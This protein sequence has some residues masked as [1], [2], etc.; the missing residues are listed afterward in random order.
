[1]EEEGGPALLSD[2]AVLGMDE[3]VNKLMLL[4]YV[5]EFCKAKS[6]VPFHRQYFAL[7]GANGALQFQ[8]FLSLVTYLTACCGRPFKGD[9]SEDP[10]A[11]VNRLVLELKD[12][13]GME[14]D[15][16]PLKLKTGSGEAC[17]KVLN[18]LCD[19]ALQARSFRFT[20]PSYAG[21]DT[22]V[23]SLRLC[24]FPTFLGAQRILTH[25]SLFVLQRH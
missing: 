23:H 11:A 17:V 15:F 21:D 4:D 6:I 5:K 18:F 3:V 7:P 12:S 1:M 16:P 8:H 20:K 14:M 10:A 25:S 22:R 24:Q 13:M 9:K 19:A 2:Y